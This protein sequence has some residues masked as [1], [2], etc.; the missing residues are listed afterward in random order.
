MFTYESLRAEEDAL[1]R[2]SIFAEYMVAADYSF[3]FEIADYKHQEYDQDN[4][5]VFAIGFRG[6]FRT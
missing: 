4:M 5:T 6:K 2:I 3:V 1:T